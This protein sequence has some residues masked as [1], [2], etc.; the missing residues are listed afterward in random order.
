M[1]LTFT[2]ICDLCKGE[3]QLLKSL[4]IKTAKILDN[5]YGIHIKLKN[6]WRICSQCNYEICNIILKYLENT[7]RNALLQLSDD[8][9]KCFVCGTSKIVRSHCLKE[10]V[11]KISEKSSL[12]EVYACFSCHFVVSIVLKYKDYLK[13]SQLWTT[14]THSCKNLII[15]SEPAPVQSPNPTLSRRKNPRPTKLQPAIKKC[16][17]VLKKLDFATLSEQLR[18]EKNDTENKITEEYSPKPVKK[19]VVRLCQGDSWTKSGLTPH[20]ESPSVKRKRKIPK[21]E[22][23]IYFKLNDRS[24]NLK[25]KKVQLTKQLSNSTEILPNIKNCFVKLKRCETPV[26]SPTTEEPKSP[27]TTPR[28]EPETLKE[29]STPNISPLFPPISQLPELH[30]YKKEFSLPPSLQEHK[31]LLQ[32]SPSVAASPEISPIKSLLSHSQNNNKHGTP[33]KS[34]SFSVDDIEIFEYTPEASECEE[35]ID[36]I[37]IAALDE[38]LTSDANVTQ[39]DEVEFETVIHNEVEVNKVIHEIISGL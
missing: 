32:K 13:S 15:S 21:K 34:V 27:I 19:P 36:Q 16:V 22:D 18:E 24:E 5:V 3:N 4:P 7:T 23:F 11:A 39:T 33:N 35:E 31:N 14:A 29:N 20:L 8:L 38:Y 17:V 26:P 10:V 37:D 12:E 25:R 30:K 6:M 28:K 2:G 9:T 1:D